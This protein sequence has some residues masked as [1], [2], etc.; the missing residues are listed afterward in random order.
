MIDGKKEPLR[1]A[2]GEGFREPVRLRAGDGLRVAAVEDQEGKISA[3]IERIIDFKVIRQNLKSKAPGP[4]EVYDLSRDH[5]ETD[6]LAAR[7]SDLVEQAVQI[8]RREIAENAVFPV[9][10]PGVNTDA[11]PLTNTVP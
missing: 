6:D 2:R 10:I 8:L 4:W 3:E 1:G 11:P 7:R 5:A 9:P